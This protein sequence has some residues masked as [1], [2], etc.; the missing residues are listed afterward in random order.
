M[1]AS[2]STS[3]AAAGTRVVKSSDIRVLRRWT[4]FVPASFV[5]MLALIVSL[6]WGLPP[7]MTYVPPLLILAAIYCWTIRRPGLMPALLVFLLGVGVDVV[8]S[9]PIGFWSFLFLTGYAVA[10]RVENW[11][12]PW[13]TLVMVV[14]FIPTAILVGGLAWAIASIY[15]GQLIDWHPAAAS[16]RTTVMICPVVAIATRMLHEWMTKPS[17]REAMTSGARNV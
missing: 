8:T 15:F 14:T 7:D 1:T 16:V 6:P 10:R 2:A 17:S 9:S 12:M 5:L 13:P 11:G 3:V 4:F